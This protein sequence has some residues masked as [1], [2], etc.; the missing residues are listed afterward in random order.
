MELSWTGGNVSHK[1]NVDTDGSSPHDELITRSRL[2]F[3][4]N[5]RVEFLCRFFHGMIHERVKAGQ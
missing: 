5:F 1:P 4:A 3:A 2:P